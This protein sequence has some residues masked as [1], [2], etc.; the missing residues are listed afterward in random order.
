[1]SPD[2]HVISL[3]TYSRHATCHRHRFARRGG[4]AVAVLHAMEHE[5]EHSEHEHSEHELHKWWLP[6]EAE[7]P[8]LADLGTWWQQFL[9]VAAVGVP[10]AIVYLCLFRQPSQLRRTFCLF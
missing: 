9:M 10:L 2:R 3:P 7:K 8:Q 6:F 1:M 5:H 4:L